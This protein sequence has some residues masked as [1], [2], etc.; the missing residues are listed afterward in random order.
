MKFIPSKINVLSTTADIE[1]FNDEIQKEDRD[2]AR[3]AQI[4]NKIIAK[5]FARGLILATVVVGTAVVVTKIVR[6][7]EDDEF[8]T[9]TDE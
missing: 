6:S 9:E 5:Q 2:D 7:D 4:R 3:L 8:E 1:A